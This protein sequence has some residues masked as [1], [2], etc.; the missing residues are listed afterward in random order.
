MVEQARMVFDKLEK[1]EPGEARLAD[2]CQ[3]IERADAQAPVPEPETIEEISVEERFRTLRQRKLPQPPSKS[4]QTER[5]LSSIWKHRSGEGFLPKPAHK[6]AAAPGAGLD[7]SM[8]R[9]ISAAQ[10][11]GVLGEFVSDLEASFGDNFLAACCS[12]GQARAAPSQRYVIAA[13]AA[14][15]RTRRSRP[16]RLRPR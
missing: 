2:L 4:G 7:G 1:H 5:I 9:P 14:S 12:A 15:V 6:V 13:I 3:E 8:R 10:P 11:A 16:P